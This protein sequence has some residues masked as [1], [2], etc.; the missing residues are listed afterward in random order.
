[1]IYYNSR[2]KE[3]IEENIAA[4]NIMVNNNLYHTTGELLDGR[5]YIEASEEDYNQQFEVD[6]VI[7]SIVEGHKLPHENNQSNFGSGYEYHIVDED[8]I[9]VKI[10]G[11]WIRFES[12]D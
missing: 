10:D 8:N 11:L 1:M 5:P 12:I 6:G 4:P 3:T 2:Q 7:V 9:L